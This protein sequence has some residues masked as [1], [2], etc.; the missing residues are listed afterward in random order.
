ML[1]KFMS[2]QALSAEKFAEGRKRFIDKVPL[3]RLAQP[4]DVAY[5]DCFSHR[6][7]LP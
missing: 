1:P 3:G 7:K 6:M 4:E 5:G 2:S